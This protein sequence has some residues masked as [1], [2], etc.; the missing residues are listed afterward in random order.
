MRKFLVFLVAIL[1]FGL[2]PKARAQST[3]AVQYLL[4]ATNQERTSHH[5]PPLR[6]D[7]ALAQAAFVHATQM[8]DHGTLSHRFPGE[9]ELS[10]RCAEAGAR[11]NRITENVA[12]G[13][14]AVDLHEGWMRSPG[15]RANILDPAVDAVGIAVVT[16]NGQLYAVQDFQHTIQD[17]TLEQQE[18]AVGM[19]LDQAGLEL[20]PDTDART[21]CAMSSGYAGAHQP[22]F[23]VRYTTADLSSLPSQLQTRLAKSQDRQASIGA[24]APTEK[25]GFTHYK[26]AILLYP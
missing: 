14:T 9:P 1:F 25:N 11:F 26:I 13:P 12:E 24:C 10:T 6:F 5:L 15:H 19:L 3:V 16:R 7:A 22:N 23:I 4:S 20:L 18:A 17:L 8:A 21:T 2:L